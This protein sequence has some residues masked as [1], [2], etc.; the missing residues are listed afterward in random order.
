VGSR[1]GLDVMEWRKISCLCLL[2][3]HVDVCRRFGSTYFVHVCAKKCKPS[4]DKGGTAKPCREKG[5]RGRIQ[6]EYPEDG[7]NTSLQTFEHTF[8][9]TSRP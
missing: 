8:Y 9:Q 7:C 2:V 4:V 6:S 3:R 5:R 1:T